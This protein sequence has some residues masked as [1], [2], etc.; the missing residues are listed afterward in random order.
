MYVFL[1]F[2]FRLAVQL[3]A[4]LGAR[5]VLRWLNTLVSSLGSGENGVSALELAETTTAREAV[6]A[7]ARQVCI[8]IEKYFVFAHAIASLST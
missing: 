3:E 2:F 6:L 1:V 8:S 7:L 4:R 5:I